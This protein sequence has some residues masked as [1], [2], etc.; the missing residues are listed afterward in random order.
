M[1]DTDQELYNGT[2]Q[3]QTTDYRQQ[4]QKDILSL[5]VFYLSVTSTL[6]L[7][8]TIAYK[9]IHTLQIYVI[10]VQAPRILHHLG[11]M[12]EVIINGYTNKKKS[13]KS[14][15]KLPPKRSVSFLETFGFKG[16]SILISK[17]L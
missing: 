4:Q 15:K 6:E 12:N 1:L 14:P 10:I 2:L 7:T 3:T 9:E 5:C 11:Y 13:G 16:K 8:N 17:N